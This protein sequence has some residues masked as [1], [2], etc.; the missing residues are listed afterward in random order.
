[1]TENLLEV[2]DL[3]VRYGRIPVVHGIDLEIKRGAVV[4]L[5]GANGAGKSTTMRAILGQRQMS[6]TVQFDGQT[7]SGRPTHAIARMGIAMVPEGRRVFRSL[8]VLHNL[9]VGAM[10]THGG[11]RDDEVLEEVLALFPEL[12]PLLKRPAGVL[13]GGQQ[14]MLAVGRAMMARPKLMVLDEPSLGLAPLVIQRIYDAIKELRSR[15]MSILLAEQNAAMALTSVDYAYVLQTGQI[16][17]HGDAAA[18]SS[19]RRVEEI[20]LGV[21]KTPDSD[22][23]VPG[24]R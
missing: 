24:A 15:D 13:S 21:S 7:I 18:L 12:V 9:R 6:G 11:W 22:R 8:T 20:Y 10:P 3:R 19:S 14:Q 23:A 5:L 4:G 2:R 17:E 1:M 16:V